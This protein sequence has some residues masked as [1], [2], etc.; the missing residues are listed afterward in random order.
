MFLKDLQTKADV[1]AIPTV[2]SSIPPKIDVVLVE[3]LAPVRCSDLEVVL[4][5]GTATAA[6]VINS[7]EIGIVITAFLWYLL[8]SGHYCCSHWHYGNVENYECQGP[9]T[10]KPL[11]LRS[12][13]PVVKSDGPIT[14]PVRTILC[15]TNVTNTK[16]G[17]TN[18][19]R[20]FILTQTFEFNLQFKTNITLSQL[21][22]NNAPNSM[23]QSPIIKGL[24]SQLS[25]LS[26]NTAQRLPN[27]DNLSV[28]NI[29][30]PVRSRLIMA[31]NILYGS[32][33]VIMRSLRGNCEILCH[34]LQLSYG[35]KSS[36]G[37][38]RCYRVGG[39]PRFTPD[40]RDRSSAIRSTDSRPDGDNAETPLDELKCILDRHA[41]GT[42]PIV[43]QGRRR[44]PPSRR[45]PEGSSR[46]KINSR[47]PVRCTNDIPVIG[48][49]QNHLR[50]DSVLRLVI[51][52]IRDKRL[53]NWSPYVQQIHVL[54]KY[55]H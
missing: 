48:D 42:P 16:T 51:Q 25:V 37:Y 32:Q 41:R 3:V 31:D 45:I 4:G 55:H 15:Y 33:I 54:M 18:E 12:R 17:S 9:T 19:Q 50:L 24:K 20:L 38:W 34:H 21:P 44:T 26:I 40:N 5:E 2:L 11:F 27:S 10:G 53:L 46:N 7:V 14:T 30:I 49:Q 8:H 13:N 47:G 28:H 52:R 22:A 43:R 35:G 36:D 29:S 39:P 6:I 1:G 23:I